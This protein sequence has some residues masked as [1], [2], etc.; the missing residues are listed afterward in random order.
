PHLGSPSADLVVSIRDTTIVGHAFSAAM[1]L[2]GMPVGDGAVDDLESFSPAID[3]IGLTRVGSH[4]LAGVGG[5]SFDGFC[6]GLSG[7]FI[8]ILA[9][10]TDET[11]PELLST[12]FGSAPNDAVVPLNS[13]NG[14]LPSQATSPSISGVDGVHFCVTSSGVYTD[15]V[16]GLLNTPVTSDAF[17]F[18]PPVTMS[19]A[20]IE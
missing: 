18:F 7:T 4:A 14:F 9:F 10:F 1:Y 17:Q 8:K 13:E 11:V 19:P 3:A 5:S 2:A 15:A 20:G 6:P 16:T 12:V